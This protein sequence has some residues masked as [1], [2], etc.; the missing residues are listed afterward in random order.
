MKSLTAFQTAIGR[1]LPVRV[2]AHF[3]TVPDWGPRH[4]SEDSEGASW[5]VV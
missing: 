3:G 1:P 2:R 5:I 4:Q